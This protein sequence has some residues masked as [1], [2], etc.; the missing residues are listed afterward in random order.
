MASAGVRRRAGLHRTA[1]KKRGGRPVA[2]VPSCL[3]TAP[4]GSA[5]RVEV[6]IAAGIFSSFGV[7]P[8]F[9]G[10]QAE[11]GGIRLPAPS[12]DPPEANNMQQDARSSDSGI[13]T[14][15]ITR[16]TGFSGHFLRT[17]RC[18]TRCMDKLPCCN[19][20][21]LKFVIRS[22]R[23]PEAGSGRD[24]SAMRSPP[25]RRGERPDISTRPITDGIA[26]TRQC[27]KSSRKDPRTP[28]AP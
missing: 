21:Y 27:R 1:G 19:T 23:S 6:A 14:G 22:G 25:F 16:E 12:E 3:I 4:P 2:S 10:R 5:E 26:G 13:H 24:L 17:R 7:P 18:R 8:W 9:S 15:I 20:D 11:T 28:G